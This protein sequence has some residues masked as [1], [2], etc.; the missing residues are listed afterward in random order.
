MSM[1][2]AINRMTIQVLLKF[3]EFIRLYHSQQ[4][5]V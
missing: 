2:G 1:F 4:H 3:L 5:H